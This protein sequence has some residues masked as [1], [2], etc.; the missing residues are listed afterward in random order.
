MR[1]LFLLPILLVISL[2]LM[3][4]GCQKR[5]DDN[6]IEGIVKLQLAVIEM[7]KRNAELCQEKIDSLY[8]ELDAAQTEEEKI[9]IAGEIYRVKELLEANLMLPGVIEKL[10]KWAVGDG[11]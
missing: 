6:V 2:S 8:K 1:K 9:K 7:S 11:D 4:G 10:R 5:A 3:F